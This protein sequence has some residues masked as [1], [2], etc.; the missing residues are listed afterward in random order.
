MDRSNNIS[1]NCSEKWKPIISGGAFIVLGILAGSTRI[2][3][4]VNGNITKEGIVVTC[5]LNALANLISNQ[6][7]T[8]NSYYKL[9]MTLMAIAVSALIAPYLVSISPYYALVIGLCHEPLKALISTL[10]NQRAIVREVAGSISISNNNPSYTGIIGSDAHYHF[11]ERMKDENKK[12]ISVNATDFYV[13]ISATLNNP[14]VRFPFDHLP[15][16]LFVGKEESEEVNF[17]IDDILYKLHT[18]SIADQLPLVMSNRSETPQADNELLQFNLASGC[19]FVDDLN[20][21]QGKVYIEPQ[22]GL[23]GRDSHFAFQKHIKT[24]DKNAIRIDPDD[25]YVKTKIIP[26][27]VGMNFIPEYLPS[28]LFKGNKKGEL[29]QF[30]Y[31]H[32]LIELS[33]TS[34]ATNEISF[35]S[36]KWLF[37]D[38]VVEKIHRIGSIPFSNQAECFICK[39][40]KLV[41]IPQKIFPIQDQA[42]ELALGK[43]KV[44]DTKLKFIFEVPISEEG[45]VWLAVHDSYIWVVM[46]NKTGIIV[47][48]DGI[49]IGG[50]DLSYEL[51]SG[52]A[53]LF[54]LSIDLR[55]TAL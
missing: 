35:D 52:I 31:D 7:N 42:A 43:S 34:F 48:L 37:P 20:P 2:I 54:R 23:I 15:S 14:T 1:I 8:K 22:T 3:E 28:S 10:F 44:I 25:F 5:A 39:E 30:Y 49:K 32:L 17:Y 9:A 13:P 29:V 53:N 36:K 18:H 38:D 26:N 51:I 21:I 27:G 6:I 55:Q 16:S 33:I 11:I 50:N 45:Q 12:P 47:E 24:M 4:W 19:F 41:S 40:G 46:Q